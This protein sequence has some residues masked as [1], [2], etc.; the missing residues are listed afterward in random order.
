MIFPEQPDG[1][2]LNAETP[3]PQAGSELNQYIPV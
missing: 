2:T 1:N 3:V